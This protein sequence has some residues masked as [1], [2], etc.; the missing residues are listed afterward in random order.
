EGDARR[1]QV[2]HPGDRREK[3]R[4]PQPDPQGYE[5]ASPGREGCHA[6]DFVLVPAR[7]RG[8]LAGRGRWRRDREYT[9]ARTRSPGS[10]PFEDLTNE[11]LQARRR[12]ILAA[13][14]IPGG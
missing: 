12:P 8:P 9:G 3:D 5:R 14:R 2:R 6:Y 4:R 11:E 1:R 13:A 10:Y 7:N